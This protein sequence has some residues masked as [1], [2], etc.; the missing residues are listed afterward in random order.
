VAAS[1]S[2]GAQ[3]FLTNDKRLPKLEEL[4]DIIVMDDFLEE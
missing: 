4:I 3:A 2:F 1:I